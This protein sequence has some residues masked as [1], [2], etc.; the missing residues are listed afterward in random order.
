MEGTA[1]REWDSAWEA[2]SAAAGGAGAT[3]SLQLSSLRRVR[4]LRRSRGGRRVLETGS[5]LVCSRSSLSFSFALPFLTTPFYSAPPIYNGQDL[6]GYIAANPSHH[7]SAHAGE[8]DL[9][10]NYA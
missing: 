7:P 1:D 4:R 10:P 6:P 9:L 5:E 2:C 8:G 3:L